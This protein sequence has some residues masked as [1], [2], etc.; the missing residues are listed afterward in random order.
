MTMS[1]LIITR[2]SYTVPFQV[3]D[4][5]KTNKLTK[6]QIFPMLR[7]CFI[8]LQPEEDADETVKVHV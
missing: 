1:V 8:K 7:G 2:I 6:E 3:Y 5:M 4:L